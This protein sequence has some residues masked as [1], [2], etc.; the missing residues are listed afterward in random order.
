MWPRPDN[1]VRPR[2]EIRNLFK[3]PIYLLLLKVPLF[4]IGIIL[5]ITYRIAKFTVKQSINILVAVVIYTAYLVESIGHSL[6]LI[7]KAFFT[8]VRYLSAKFHRSILQPVKFFTYNSIFP[9]IYDVSNWIAGTIVWFCVHCYQRIILPAIQFCYLCIIVPAP[10]WINEFSIICSSTL[11]LLFRRLRSACIWSWQNILYPLWIFIFIDVLLL[12]YQ[13][14]VTIGSFVYTEL[15]TPLSRYVKY[16]MRVIYYNIP[17]LVLH[18]STCVVCTIDSFCDA[19]TFFY[20]RTMLPLYQNVVKIGSFVYTELLTPLSRH[21]KYIVQIIYYN[22]LKLLLHVS[23]CVVCT[24]G[25]FYDACACFSEYTLLP[26]CRAILTICPHI[27]REV[28]KPVSRLALYTA[29]MLCDKLYQFVFHPTWCALYLMVQ[30]FDE[31]LLQPL[32]SAVSTLL[33]AIVEV[34]R[35]IFIVVHS[36]LNTAALAIAASGKAVGSIFRTDT[37]T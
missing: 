32:S 26:F 28:L 3:G 30:F 23:T 37:H 29:R 15:L 20:R 4:L 12:L 13:S 9:V 14:I 31:Y 35:G 25:S 34:F 24:T 5:Y 7:F 10:A 11:S 2:D 8:Y 16:I 18:A 21:V 17:K 1:N 27:Y 33:P 22:V 6:I 19:C 36:G